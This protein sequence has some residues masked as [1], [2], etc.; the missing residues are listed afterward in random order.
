MLIIHCQVSCC[1]LRNNFRL[2]FME[3]GKKEFIFN[4]KGSIFFS[5]SLLTHECT[6]TIPRI[7]EVD[8]NLYQ[9]F[10]LPWPQQ[11][12]PNYLHFQCGE[13]WESLCTNPPENIHSRCFH[14][15]LHAQW[16]EP[17]AGDDQS[18]STHS[19]WWKCTLHSFQLWRSEWKSQSVVTSA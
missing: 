3:K 15:R 4:I 10:T 2:G 12:L 16:L 19:H 17:C 8:H 5:P 7:F 18:L 1:F 13:C 6:S 9:T 14:C 11:H